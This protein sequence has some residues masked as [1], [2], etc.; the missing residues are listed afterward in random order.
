MSTFWATA[1]VAAGL[2]AILGLAAAAG[3]AA[4][5]AYRLVRGLL[6][7]VDDWR[8]EPDRDGVPGR[9]GVMARLA[10][11][12]G[13]LVAQAVRLDRQDGRLARLESGVEQ[14]HGEL[15]P[16]G[17]ATLRDAVNRVE[18]QLG[19]SGPPPTNPT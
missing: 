12:D 10:R 7:I 15:K 19:T 16:N 4:Q 6:N 3:K 5:V 9:L 17:G 1:G 2:A 18:E 11:Q 8:G 13:Q 14:V